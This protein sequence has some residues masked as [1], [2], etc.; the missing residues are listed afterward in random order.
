MIEPRIYRAAFVPA[1]VATVLAAFS[2][3]ARPRPLPQGLAAD[4]LFDGNIA[5]SQARAIAAGAPD[6]RPGRRGD[7][8]TAN[9]VA[10][11]L[12]GRGFSVER[13][14][15]TRDDEQLVNV[16]GR[17]PGKSRRQI[18][19]VAGRD[20]AA[21]PDVPGSAGDTAALLEL[22]RVFE[23]RP[24]RKTLVLA[25]VDGSTLG[26]AGAD[27]L[28][29]RLGDPGLVDAVLV[30]SDL[31]AKRR[32]GGALVAWSNGHERAGIGRPR[33]AA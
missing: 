15:F 12:S 22:A 14:R 20:A 24:S 16:I 11:S 29:D 26:Q 19:V 17:R 8:A 7:V 2:L 18:V 4:V 6:R 5:G 28:A 32:K 25:S 9:R 27:E 31:G 3:E 21:V 1:L 13:V 30:M 23:G 10:A 33:T